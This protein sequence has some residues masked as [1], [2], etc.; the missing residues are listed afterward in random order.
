LMLF[1][2]GEADLRK[3]GL[4]ADTAA[5][6]ANMLQGLEAQGFPLLD[7][8][9]TIH[10]DRPDN[11]F[12]QAVAAFQALPEGITHFIIHPS[13]DTPELRAITPDFQARVEDHRT[14]L[15]EDLRD[16]IRAMGVH[17][18]GYRKLW[19]LLN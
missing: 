13:A 5:M 17:V 7:G 8:M 2:W 18:I 11:R 19:E 10:L 14:F 1:R 9:S 4:D 6:A 12:E 16:A 15:R 3:V